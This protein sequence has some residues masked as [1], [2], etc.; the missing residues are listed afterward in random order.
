MF[1]I[2]SHIYFFVLTHVHYVYIYIY[3]FLV[4][5]RKESGRETERERIFP[6]RGSVFGLRSGVFIVGGRV[7]GTCLFVPL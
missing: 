7:W 3:I 6:L 4:R 5:E 1:F 2:F